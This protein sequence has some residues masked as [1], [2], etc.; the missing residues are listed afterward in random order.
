MANAFSVPQSMGQYVEPINLNL[1]NA[2]LSSKQQRYDYNV[3]KIDSL[4]SEFSSIEL[5]R[6]QDKQYLADRV[7]GVLNTV[8]RVQKKNLASNSLTRDITNYIG[9]A[10]DDKVL[11]QA[12]NTV[13]LKAFE[14]SIA[15]R[16]EKK[17]DTYSDLNYTFAKEQAGVGEY[18]QGESDGFGNL[19]YAEYKDVNKRINDFTLDLL[20]K[21]KDT[22]VEIPEYDSNGAPTGYMI[23]KT[24]RGLTPDQIRS[25]AESQLDA[26][27]LQQIKINGWYNAG[28]YKDPQ[29]LAGINANL[30]SMIESSLGSIDSQ[31][32]KLKRD[33]DNGVADSDVDTQIQNLENNKTNI[34]KNIDT[35]KKDPEAAA[36]FIEKER[37]LSGAVSTFKNFY[38][39]DISY[40]AN[41]AYYKEQNLAL[42]RA[43][44]DYE[45]SKDLGVASGI[46]E[47]Y[48]TVTPT[49][50]PEEV[51][52]YQESIDTQISQVS[53]DTKNVRD[54][55]INALE[56]E[57]S[58]GNKEAANFLTEYN[59]LKKSN[60]EG[61]SDEVVFDNLIASTTY[62]DKLNILG[63]TNFRYNLK[64]SK[65]RET[66]L[67]KGLQEAKSKG[68][69]AHVDSTINSKEGLKA[70]YNNP[71]TKM[72]FNGKAYSVRNLLIT[73]GVI[74]ENGNKIGDLKTKP[75]LM[76]E[77]QKSFYA[78][79]VL[80]N[81]ALPSGSGKDRKS[82]TTSLNS[83]KELAV[84]LGE[85]PK[86]VY[87]TGTYA[88]GADTLGKEVTN[89]IIK[90]GTKTANYLAKAKE[91][92]VYDTFSWSD[93][94][95]S[96]DDATIG[97]FLKGNYKETDVYKNEIK[98][99][100]NN[101]PSNQQLS[102]PNTD[103]ANFE[104]LRGYMG[105]SSAD[106]AKD[107]PITIS[108]KG[109]SVILTQAHSEGS[110]EK[111]STTPIQV[112]LTQEEFNRNFG[113]LGNK[114]NFNNE[115]QFYTTD[116]MQ[117][118]K[119]VSEPIKYFSK[120]DYKASS[121]I[122]NKVL[123]NDTAR[124]M[125]G[126]FLTEGDTY[127]NLYTGHQM[128]SRRY[129]NGQF[130]SLLR[131]ALSKDV[132][133]KFAVNV[134]VDRDY[135]GEPILQVNLTS[136][137]GDNI[138]SNIIRGNENITD[139]KA[140]LDT[141]P[142]VYYGMMLDSILEEEKALMASGSTAMSE[143]L[144]KLSKYLP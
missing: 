94:S 79:D 80:S 125:F 92:G 64:E 95:L 101:L 66:L 20:S 104:K 61:L 93:Q 133:S 136:Q 70:F 124:A 9:T 40:S 85:N 54:S 116:K 139:F 69:S 84:M 33:K 19:Q 8:N 71:D 26:A 38:S 68:I 99:Y 29:A 6:D 114:L 67:M 78:D 18:L 36:T 134:V 45:R 16:R 131:S 37:V 55:Y 11:E 3:A 135:S 57:A 39:E 41:E 35:Y 105:I 82:V 2:A 119:L 102:I 30:D 73:N 141:A 23:K 90:P 56:T 17:P 43:K 44:F 46:G 51:Q 91:Q 50:Y 100:Y 24:V 120:A 74:D 86:D 96:G 32:L 34:R 62:K 103:K 144:T 59:N 98:K 87:M 25:V 76:K 52:S 63:D 12:S 110:G 117:G 112:S 137:S 14:Q 72:M 31:I 115:A 81:L 10:I 140:I 83:L 77:L 1:V 65:D 106:V 130:D 28:G 13:R 88:G 123:K 42:E 58:K 60:K 49:E 97:S 7:N 89:F 122:T 132:V 27:H 138:H 121:Y 111:K 109:D 143:G 15:E 113:A 4:L 129:P 107:M 47:A 48:T 53:A 5:I 142:Q 118:Q 22:E 108:K 126:G 75:N 127:K 128:L 21:N